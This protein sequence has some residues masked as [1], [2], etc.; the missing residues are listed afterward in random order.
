MRPLFLGGLRLSGRRWSGEPFVR[1]RDPEP[2]P[3]R[4]SLHPSSVVRRLSS[5]RPIRSDPPK[6][7]STATLET[8]SACSRC[9]ICRFLPSS[10]VISSQQFLPPR[11]W[12]RAAL[13]CRRSLPQ[14][15]LDGPGQQIF[16]LPAG[17][18]PSCAFFFGRGRH[19]TTRLVHREVDLRSRCHGGIVHPIRS[20]PMH[21]GV[22]G[23]R[24]VRLFNV[25]RPAQTSAAAWDREQ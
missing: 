17:H 1:S 12:T 19:H 4:A 5:K 23:S 22:S 20:F 11:R 7:A 25:T 18:K 16:L 14:Q 8:P 10:S 21:T 13:A 9:R 2:G 24:T 15:G 6:R 3:G